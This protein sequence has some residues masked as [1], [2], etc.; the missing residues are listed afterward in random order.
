MT[1][2]RASVTLAGEQLTS[3]EVNL[4]LDEETLSMAAGDSHIGTWSLD[5]VSFRAN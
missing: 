3:L 4:R 2:Y 1:E 5:D